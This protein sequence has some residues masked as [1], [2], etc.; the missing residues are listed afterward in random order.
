MGLTGNEA[1]L[2]T[3]LESDTNA[4]SDY[5]VEQICGTD[6]NDNDED[7]DNDDEVQVM[8]AEC[9]V[10]KATVTRKEVMDCVLMP[11]S[12]F[13]NDKGKGKENKPPK[14]VS[15]S[16]PFRVSQK[17][18]IEVIRSDDPWMKPKNKT[19]PSGSSQDIVIAE[20]KT[21]PRPKEPSH[22]E[23]SKTN[24]GKPVGRQSEISAGVEDIQYT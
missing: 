21:K 9:S 5:Y 16:E 18:P 15:N 6:L 19:T 8:A 24:K 17:G 23:V 4:E 10:K 22:E 7:D 1:H 14:F 12:R 2:I 11:P 20:P 13:N 3:I